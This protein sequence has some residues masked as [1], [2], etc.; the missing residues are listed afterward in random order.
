[1]STSGPPRSAAQ[2]MWQGSGTR[3]AYDDAGRPQRLPPHGPS[4]PGLR[5]R[6]REMAP[7]TLESY[8]VSAERQ[9]SVTTR[10]RERRHASSA[11][12]GV[13]DELESNGVPVLVAVAKPVGGRAYW[14]QSVQ[15]Y[16]ERSGGS[17][18]DRM[19]LAH[20]RHRSIRVAVRFQRRLLRVDRRR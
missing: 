3:H 5:S 11:E 2:T 16:R 1:M 19:G 9:S 17:W 8:I 20:R 7:F 6:A 18:R 4:P 12:F 13:L 10:R 15:V 14:K